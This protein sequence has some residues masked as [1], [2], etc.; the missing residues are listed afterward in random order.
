MSGI[1]STK[2]RQKN[3]LFIWNRKYLEIE[4]IVEL[5]EMVNLWRGLPKK[6]FVF[7]N[8]EVIVN[9]K[10]LEKKG[11]YIYEECLRYRILT[12]DAGLLESREEAING[13]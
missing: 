3:K 5:E 1:R 8:W 10:Y 9:L 4:K 11:C 12:T 6:K 7:F 13:K 2:K